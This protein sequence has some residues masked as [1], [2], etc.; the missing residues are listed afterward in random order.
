MR[1][2]DKIAV[3]TGAASGIGRAS[4]VLFAA[5]GAEVV[6]VDL[7]APAN[8]A[9]ARDIQAAGGHA[10]ASYSA[11]KGGLIPLTHVLAHEFGA[12]GIRVNCLAP[13]GIVTGMTA[14]AGAH[15][16]VVRHI[17]IG[18]LGNAG[19]VAQAA[20]FLASDEASYTTG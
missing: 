20:L 4:A 13:G 19:E 3:I 16:P 18:R 1:L 14:G 11:A 17:P 15:S 2:P 8:D 7:N 5:E 9:T 6:C 12:H 10:V